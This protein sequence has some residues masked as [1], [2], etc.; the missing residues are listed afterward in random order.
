M[1]II[2]NVT[3]KECIIVDDIVDSGGTLCNAASALKNNG[4]L[5]VSAYITHGV[6]SGNA[7]DKI[8]NSQLT[9]LTITDTIKH[10]SIN[11]PKIK[12]LSIDRFLS[13]YILHN[14]IN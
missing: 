13:N 12:V 10:Y 8:A 6:L 2:G 14:L 9:T 3:N 7:L 1:N 11:T 4:A 5:Q